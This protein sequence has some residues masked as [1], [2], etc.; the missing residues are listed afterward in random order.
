MK[1][2]IRESAHVK[3]YV[4]DYSQVP[5]TLDYTP[6]F[7]CITPKG[8]TEEPILIKDTDTLINTFG[9]PSTN[10][11][12]YKDMMTIRDFVALNHSCWVK[13]L[14]TEDNQFPYVAYIDNGLRSVLRI[15][16][17]YKGYDSL[18]SEKKRI[19]NCGYW[20]SGYSYL[21]FRDENGNDYYY[22]FQTVEGLIRDKDE[23]FNQSNW[24]LTSYPNEELVKVAT[25]HNAQQLFSASVYRGSK[26]I[27]IAWVNTYSSETVCHYFCHNYNYVLDENGSIQYNAL[28]ERILKKQKVYPVIRIN[29]NEFTLTTADDPNAVFLVDSKET[30]YTSIRDNRLY[31]NNVA[32]D[33]YV[34]EEG[35]ITLSDLVTYNYSLGGQ[36]VFIDNQCLTDKVNRVIHTSTDDIDVS[37]YKTINLYS[38]IE[39][40]LLAR[41]VSITVPSGYT[42]SDIYL[43]AND[44]VLYN[45]DVDLLLYEYT[46]PL[47]QV[48]KKIPLLSYTAFTPLKPASAGYK[49]DYV[50]YGVDVTQKT[51]LIQDTITLPPNFTNGQF[52]EKMQSAYIHMTVSNPES[53]NILKAFTYRFWYQIIDQNTEMVYKNITLETYI[54][55]L[56]SYE[57]P[58][59]YG[60]FIGDLSFPMLSHLNLLPMSLD[61]RKAIQYIIKTIA[62]KRKDLI[63]IFT[64]PNI[65]VDRACD[66]TNA[67]G[68]FSDYYNYGSLNTD[69]Y[70][71][72]SFYC[73]MYYGWLNYKTTITNGLSYQIDEVAPTIFVIKN[74]IDS[75]ILKGISYPVAGD[76]GGVLSTNVLLPMTNTT[77]KST[78][79]YSLSTI[80]NLESKS[81]RDKLIAN[82]INPIYDTGLRGI[83]IYG[84]ETLNPA[85]TDLSAAHIGRMVVV[86]HNLVTQYT[87]KI[88]FS[89]NNQYTWG[90]WVNY[91]STKILDPIKSAGGL[92]WYRVVM[93]REI[94]PPEE[95]A[96]R[97]IRGLVSLQFQ[98]DLEIV[99]LDYIVNPSSA[100]M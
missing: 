45:L 13:R 7:V 32:S 41:G 57:D 35:Y 26:Y 90:S 14:D 47:M 52:A 67:L 94:T 73:E 77:K 15:E 10:P 38:E 86:I 42:S 33:Y 50:I 99:H 71:E 2:N 61:D 25:K 17:T 34:N 8:P 92:T 78:N 43:T 5:V 20:R 55:A 23:I 36:R 93:G 63:C 24:E 39:S 75:W 53:H 70:N 48:D 88:K 12:L 51:Y 100:I 72:Q 1:A 31:L 22:D 18:P 16:F 59:Y 11:D 66:W 76:Q 87:E 98:Q 82:R 65:D 28:N 85:Y 54:E 68:E 89:L 29:D 19:V 96:Q 56:K 69:N 81:T 21:Q 3:S 91:V 95:I 27:S 58:K 74:I 46:S 37:Y 84:N 83:Q 64:T 9:D 80:N 44:K 4:K 40:A 30:L 49:V 62:E 79:P 97:K 60:T 6:M